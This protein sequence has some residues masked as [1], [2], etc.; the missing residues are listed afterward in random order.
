MH[1]HSV[2][3]PKCL[4]RF[5]GASI[6]VV[7]GE[8]NLRTC[9]LLEHNIDKEQAQDIY[10]PGANKQVKII[11]E[12]NAQEIDSKESITVEP[13]NIYNTTNVH[14]PLVNVSSENSMNRNEKVLTNT[15]NNAYNTHNNTSSYKFDESLMKDLETLYDTAASYIQKHMDQQKS[16]NSTRKLRHL[17]SH[18]MRKNK[19]QKVRQRRK[20]VQDQDRELHIQKLKRELHSDKIDGRDI[21]GQEVKLKDEMNIKRFKRN[22]EFIKPP[23]LLDQGIKHGGNADK[24]FTSNSNEASSVSSFE[25][26]L[27]NC[28][29]GAILLAHEFEPS[30]Q[31]TNTFYLLSGK[32]TQANHH[33][34]QDGYYYYIFYSDNDIVSNDIYAIFDIY[35]P[36]FQYENVTKSC[37]NATECSFSLS[38]LS[39]ERIIVEIP[40]KDGIE[41]NEMDDISILISTCQPRMGAYMIF[42]IATLLLILGCAFM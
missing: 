35:K 27:F 16:M 17:R 8:R 1:K 36:T 3:K 37:I 13:I 15:D 25:N 4:F 33:V 31:C 21:V 14:I 6:L 30:N 24:N 23:S 18:K 41:H 39:A 5:P 7:K 9:G 42:P 10:L 26:D 19:N 11:Y 20:H 38:P 34:E 2:Y 29:G 28:Y 22:Q 12:S 32:H 40:T